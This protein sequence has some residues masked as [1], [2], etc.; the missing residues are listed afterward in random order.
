MVYVVPS[1][2][3]TFLLFHHT[4]TSSWISKHVP[5]FSSSPRP[6]LSLLW[7]N[8][9]FSILSVSQNFAALFSLPPYQL[10]FRDVRVILSAY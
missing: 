3:S 1:V 6:S 10:A 9:S 5:K 4:G 7:R 8:K 2:P